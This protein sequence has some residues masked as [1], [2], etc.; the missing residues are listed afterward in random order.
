M[1]NIAPIRRALVP[2]DSAAAAQLVAPNYDE[3]QG[4][5]EVWE[6]IQAKPESILAVTMAHCDVPTET[7]IGEDGSDATLDK[8]RETLRNRIDSP[9]TKVVENVLWVYEIVDPR[10]PSVRQMGLGGAAKTADIRTDESPDGTV[11]RNEGIREEKA[12]GRANLISKT[13]SY[14]GVVN[15]TVEDESGHLITALEEYADGRECDFQADD[16]VGNTHKVWLIA[17]E[18]SINKFVELMKAE[19]FAYVAD[20]NHRSAAAALLGHDDYLAMFFTTGRMG[21]APY[22][23]LV[24]E[25]KAAELDWL[26][27]LA[28]YFDAQPRRDSEPFQPKQTHHIGLYD[29]KKWLELVPKDNA[30]DASNAAESID[31]DI[32]QRHIFEDVLQIADAR[33]KRLTFVGGNK[34]AAWLQSRVDSGD[35][36]FAVTLPPV[37]ME[38]FVSVCQ[39]NR[40]MPPKSTWFEPKIRSGLVVALLD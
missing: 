32:V 22:N 12:R 9:L 35:F 11:I 26:Q 16:E 30:Y 20:G 7:E 21:L 19:P 5:R 27:T 29:G 8:A 14:V 23:R 38:Q 25:P 24:A 17:D 2:V 34:D 6:F 37:T 15:N 31:S 13:K 39:Q 18:P 10:R 28:E 40:F 33:D 36:H 3:F 4:D 1:I